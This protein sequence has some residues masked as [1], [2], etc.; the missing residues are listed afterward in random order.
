MAPKYIGGKTQ[1]AEQT[2][3]STPGRASGAPTTCSGGRNKA[4][5]DGGVSCL[6]PAA[7]LCAW[8]SHGL[9]TAISLSGC[10]HGLAVAHS[11]R[12]HLNPPGVWPSLPI[13]GCVWEEKGPS[14]KDSGSMW[15]DREA[16]GHWLT[17][18]PSARQEERPEPLAALGQRA[19]QNTFFRKKATEA[20]LCLP[21]HCQGKDSGQNL[22]LSPHHVI[23][24]NNFRN[25]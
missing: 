6:Q 25:L 13:A 7:Q 12:L 14:S 9:G 20:K 8:D 21:S 15:T 22:G 24:R 4:C 10:S 18:A 16:T 17:H 23:S 3:S 19:K 2:T 5:A 1:T 11:Y